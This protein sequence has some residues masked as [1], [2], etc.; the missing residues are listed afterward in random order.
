MLKSE[1]VMN[2]IFLLNARYGTFFCA[3]K[4]QMEILISPRQ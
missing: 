3:I 1:C 4:C 2:N